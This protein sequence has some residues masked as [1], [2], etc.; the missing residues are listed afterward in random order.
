MDIYAYVGLRIYVTTSFTHCI[1][2]TNCLDYAEG[3]LSYH[4]K[5]NL[6]RMDYL[7]VITQKPIGRLKYKC[8]Y[9]YKH[10]FIFRDV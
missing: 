10:N 2:K 7:C 4:K 9:V 8:I 3:F 1:N 6:V 5:T